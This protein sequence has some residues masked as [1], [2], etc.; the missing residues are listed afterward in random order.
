[1]AGK[2][3][4]LTLFD[5]RWLRALSVLSWLGSA[6]CFG[7]RLPVIAIYLA[8]SGFAFLTT[9]LGFNRRHQNVLTAPPQGYE[10]TGERYPNPPGGNMVAV[11]HRGIH[12][13]YVAVNESIR[14]D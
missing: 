11:Y 7:D 3:R 10:P 6:L 9:S 2:D 13:L 5:R 8:L 12:R 14:R 4:P 1:M